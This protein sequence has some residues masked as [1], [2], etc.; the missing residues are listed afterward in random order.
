MFF[1]R[2]GGSR[3]VVNRVEKSD[4]IGFMG[5]EFILEEKEFIDGFDKG[6]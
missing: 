4:G 2:S 3:I 5:K 6:V 1:D